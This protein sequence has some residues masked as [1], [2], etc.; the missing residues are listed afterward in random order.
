[1]IL[2]ASPFAMHFGPYN[3][4]QVSNIIKTNYFGSVIKNWAKKF[5]LITQQRQHLY[6]VQYFL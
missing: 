1:M 4:A 2:P 3:L 5:F 6:K